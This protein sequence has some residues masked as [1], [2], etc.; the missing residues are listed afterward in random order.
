MQFIYFF[1]CL[2]D[3]VSLKWHQIKKKII[4]CDLA[5]REWK[6]ILRKTFELRNQKPNS[7]QKKNNIQSRSFLT[8]HKLHT[9]K[10]QWNS[11]KIRFKMLTFADKRLFFQT[12]R[13][14]VI[15]QHCAISRNNTESRNNDSKSKEL[16][17]MWGRENDIDTH[18][19][20]KPK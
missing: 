5:L 8:Q 13:D 3:H 1:F 19:K 9:N 4:K 16:N 6:P 17:P 11:I 10:F 7:K 2:S 15:Q 14:V 20:K 12:E 18:K